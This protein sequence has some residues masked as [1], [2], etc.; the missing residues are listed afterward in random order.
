MG[1][2]LAADKRQNILKGFGNED[3]EKSKSGVYADTPENRKLQRV[4]QK[5][6][7]EKKGDEPSEKKDRKPELDENGKKKPIAKT[8]EEHASTTDTETLKKVLAAE[9]TKEE[10]VSAAKKELDKRGVNVD[11]KSSE[12][13]TKEE[14][15]ANVKTLNEVIE[16]LSNVNSEE[17][18]KMMN[19]AIAQRNAQEKAM[20]EMDDEKVDKEKKNFDKK[21]K[22]RK[23]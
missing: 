10:L 12:G 13:M 3:I 6:G 2:N 4:G 20:L 16:K 23:E 8:L 11:K 22:T 9:G 19:E 15:A 17:A 18:N 7:S 5:Y 14:H 21:E 1:F